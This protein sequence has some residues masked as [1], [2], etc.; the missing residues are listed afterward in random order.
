MRAPQTALFEL[1]DELDLLELKFELGDELEF[2]L[3]DEE[4]F[5]LTAKAAAWAESLAASGN[6]STRKAAR[7]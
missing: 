3:L 2:G 6:F 1:E 5:E 7:A 4:L